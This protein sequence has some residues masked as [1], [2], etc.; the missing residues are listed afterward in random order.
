MG[1]V[2]K[3]VSIGHANS[4]QMEKNIQDTLND[5]TSQGWEYVDNMAIS[6]GGFFLNFRRDDSN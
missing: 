3:V 5:Y 6:N 2:Y 1:W 4:Q